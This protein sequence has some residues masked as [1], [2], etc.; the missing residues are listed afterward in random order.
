MSGSKVPVILTATLRHPSDFPPKYDSSMT[1]WFILFLPKMVIS[2]RNAMEAEPREYTWLDF[3]ATNALWSHLFAVHLFT[4]HFFEDFTYH[5]LDILFSEMFR[6]LSPQNWRYTW[7][8]KKNLAR[9]F[10]F[11]SNPIRRL[12][13]A[14]AANIHCPFPQTAQHSLPQIVQGAWCPAWSLSL[15]SGE[16]H[17]FYKDIAYSDYKSDTYLL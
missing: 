5:F 17:N 13:G 14:K 2:T 10:N 4:H 3:P 16:K 7:K 1:W 8:K 9:C 12:P 11:K 15:T 6:F